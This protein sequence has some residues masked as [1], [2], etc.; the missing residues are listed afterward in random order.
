[1]AIPERLSNVTEM[2]GK[3]DDGKGGRHIP[4]VL[5]GHHDG[6]WQTA[7]RAWLKYHP[8][9]THHLVLQDDLLLC[10]ELLEGVEKAL[11]Y[12]PSGDFVSLFGTSKRVRDIHLKGQTS[13]IKAKDFSGQA[14]IIP[15]EA[16]PKMVDWI[17]RCVRP[18]L[19]K[20]DVK[21][22]MWMQRA[23]R[24]CWI[25]CPSLVEHIGAYKSTRKG[26]GGVNRDSHETFIGEHKSTSEIDWSLGVEDPPTIV[27]PMPHDNWAYLGAE[28]E[29]AV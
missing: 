17:D 29:P 2:M 10:E 13:W 9:A 4:L 3:L 26:I 16:I 7:R 22:Y 1:M 28:K 24:W 25:T 11:R 23:D 8:D 14:V 12:V 21:M 19:D 18:D 20:D 5:D 6:I 27:S 15:T